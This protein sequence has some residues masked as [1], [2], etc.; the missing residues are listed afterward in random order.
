MEPNKEKA[1]V[2]FIAT[3]S[4]SGPKNRSQQRRQIRHL[5]WKHLSRIVQSRNV[6]IGDLVGVT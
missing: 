1:V 4:Q 6:I 2:L 5:Q 3:N